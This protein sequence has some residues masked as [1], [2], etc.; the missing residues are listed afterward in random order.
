MR[1]LS[2]KKDQGGATMAPDRRDGSPCDHLCASIGP[3]APGEAI[4]FV[5]PVPPPYTTVTQDTDRGVVW[6]DDRG[7]DG[8]GHDQDRDD[9]P[10]PGTG[11]TNV[12]NFAAGLQQIS[13]RCCKDQS[14]QDGVRSDCTSTDKETRL[15]LSTSLQQNS[16]PH[17]SQDPH[18]SAGT[19]GCDI[20]N[21]AN[22]RS[23]SSRDGDKPDRPESRPP[24]SCS[25][26]RKLLQTA[27]N[28]KGAVLQE[29]LPS[30]LDHQ[31][32][33]RV[34]WQGG[35]VWHPTPLFSSERN[36]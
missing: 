10:G 23:V 8:E 27:V 35:G 6:T 18:G 1:R 21:V 13:S 24:L 2:Q 7:G 26:F 4:E 30:V 11:P 15:S 12:C 19:G 17:S 9:G 33:T 3:T 14:A 34:V 36:N 25:A 5:D 29:T 32:F 28:Q 22:D 16:P 31:E 20:Q